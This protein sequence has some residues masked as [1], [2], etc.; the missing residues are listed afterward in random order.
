MVEVADWG[1]AGSRPAVLQLPRLFWGRVMG[2]VMAVGM[3]A[4]A[5]PTSTLWEAL[6]YKPVGWLTHGLVPNGKLNSIGKKAVV[7]VGTAGWQD[8]VLLC[9]KELTPWVDVKAKQMTGW[10]N[11]LFFF[12]LFLAYF[13][14]Q[15]N[16]G[17]SS[18]CLSC[19]FSVWHP[20][21]E[22]G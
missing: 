15:E 10:C 1:S 12:L 2:R 14:P 22:W 11:L 19:P 6:R 17:I 5:L 7:I 9:G 20:S 18:N 8:L 3:Q 21:V 4:A 13:L 16:M